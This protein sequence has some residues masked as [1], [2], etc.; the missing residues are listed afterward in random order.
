MC[1]ICGIALS[2][3]SSQEISR[4]TIERMRDVLTHRGPDAAGVFVEEGIALGHRRLSIVD[5]CEAAI[6]SDPKKVCAA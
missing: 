2:S 6:W 3:R 5:A 1:G 4:A